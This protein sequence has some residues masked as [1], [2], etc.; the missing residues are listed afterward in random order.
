MLLQNRALRVDPW[1]LC[2]SIEMSNWM[3]SELFSEMVDP[4]NV[5]KST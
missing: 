5:S 3:S 4:L 2:E 1:N